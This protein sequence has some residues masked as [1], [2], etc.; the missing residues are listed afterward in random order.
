MASVFLHEHKLSQSFS[1]LKNS[2]KSIKP[3]TR[4]HGQM[5]VTS[6][7]QHKQGFTTLSIENNI[8]M[9]LQMY[10]ECYQINSTAWS[11][12]VWASLGT[13][14]LATDPPNTIRIF[15]IKCLKTCNIIKI[16]LQIN[17]Q[18]T[19]LVNTFSIFNIDIAI[20]KSNTITL[21][22]LQIWNPVQLLPAKKGIQSN[23]Y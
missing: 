23:L 11:L 18:W 1:C 22:Q 21:L 10:T 8:N 20:W 2:I 9:F 13:P 7:W 4:L 19:Y 5:F 6:W 3:Q 14:L 12:M 16:E 15:D 17:Y